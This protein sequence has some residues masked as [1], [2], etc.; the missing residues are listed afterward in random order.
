[1]RMSDETDSN[2]IIQGLWIGSE[3]SVMERLSIASFLA[4]G[5]EY[6]LYSYEPVAHVP[7]GAVVKDAAEVLPRER[8]FRYT[9]GGSWSGFSNFFRYKLLLERGGWWFDTDF[10]CLKPIDLGAEHVFASEFSLGRQMVTSGAIKA[11]A[12][13][14]MM[15]YAWTVC[16]QKNPSELVWGETGPALVGEAV[17]RFS[18]DDAVMPWKA[19]C[20]IGFREWRRVIRPRIGSGIGDESYTLH[21]W[22]EMWRSA[23]ADKNRS[24]HPTSLYERLKRQY[25]GATLTPGWRLILKLTGHES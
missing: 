15:E 22:N 11:P 10:V 4:N 17:S 23:G 21:F 25:L 12:G 1:M 2:R 8:A 20:P 24:Y 18:M 14:E 7:P 19:F 5:H 6:H 13:S 3:L 9:E 16:T